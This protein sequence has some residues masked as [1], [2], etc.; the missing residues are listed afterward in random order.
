[1]LTFFVPF[2]LRVSLGTDIPSRYTLSG[3]WRETVTELTGL[4]QP[5]G[6]GVTKETT[7]QSSKRAIERT[8]ERERERVICRLVENLFPAEQTANL[9]NVRA[10]EEQTTNQTNGR[11]TELPINNERSLEP[12]NKKNKNQNQN[13][14]EKNAGATAY[15]TSRCWST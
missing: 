4:L 15:T 10:H 3:T 7:Q 9:Q 13:H 1:M 2:R 12:E 5:R 11:T 8:N 14:N 6:N